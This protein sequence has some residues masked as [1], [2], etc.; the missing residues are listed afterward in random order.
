M[1]INRKDCLINSDMCAMF[2]MRCDTEWGYDKKT[3]NIECMFFN[4]NSGSRFLL[5]IYNKKETCKSALDELHKALIR[6]DNVFEFPE[7][8]ERKNEL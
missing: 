3:Y 4:E 7:D 5:K 1:W 6:G 8:E 2:L